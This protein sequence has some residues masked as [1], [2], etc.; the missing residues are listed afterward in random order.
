MSLALMEPEPLRVPDAADALE[1]GVERT[2]FYFESQGQSLFAWL[3]R[4]ADATTTHG[5]L[6]CPPVGHEQVHAHRTLRRLADQLAA[7]GFAALRFDYH[8]T[9]DSEG[10]DHDAQRLAIWR[11]N[12]RDAAAWLRDHGGC[13]HLSLIGLRMGA[14]LAA[15]YA[16]EHRVENLVLW[17][18]IVKGRR[19]VRELT[20]LN[21]TASQ[22][23]EASSG[24]EAMGFV[25]THET[26]QA[27][28]KVDLLNVVPQCE[29]GLIVRSD[30]GT[31][32][33]VLHDHLAKLGRSIQQVAYPGYE[34]MMAEPQFTEVPGSA[35]AGIVEWLASHNTRAAKPGTL[36]RIPA[37]AVTQTCGQSPV[38]ESIHPISTELALFGILTEPSERITERPWIVMLNAGAAYHVG[39]G[40]LHVPLARHLATLGYPCLRMDITGLG[41]SPADDVRHENDAYAATA[42][43]DVAM[44]CDYLNRLQPNRPIVLMGLCSGAYAAFQSAVQFPH[45]ALVESILLNPLTFFWR[46]GMSLTTSPTQRLQTWH[47]YRGIIFDSENWRQLFSSESEAGLSGAV[48]RFFQR[49]FPRKDK[50]SSPQ[51]NRDTGSVYGHPAKEN[52]S[53]DLARVAAASRRLAMFVSEGDPGR[54]LLMHQAKRKATQLIR[55]GMLKCFSIK[56]ADHTFSTEASRQMLTQALTDYLA[57]RFGPKA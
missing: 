8:G 45:S 26:T 7:R 42:F 21:L 36:A 55:K 28:A 48:Q 24:I 47:Y 50:T 44:T 46:E 53:A 17:E 29:H 18:P 1:H 37:L 5:V 19:Y 25:F 39:P 56:G 15:L 3:H 52:L 33:T 30:K 2:A 11:A 16:D 35:L 41:D 40:R 49:M 43:R 57:S 6:I 51:A 22:A 9:G 4:P 13:S 32:D 54:F 23:T 14:T 10:S 34:E 38:R 27:L 12:V 31:K 20:A